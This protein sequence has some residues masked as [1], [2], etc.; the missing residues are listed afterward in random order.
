M[1]GV[2]GG[3]DMIAWDEGQDHA[4][5]EQRAANAGVNVVKQAGIG[6]LVAAAATV[7]ANV[8]P[9]QGGHA[10][11]PPEDPFERVHV[12]HDD[13]LAK[14]RL[15]NEQARQVIEHNIQ[16]RGTGGPHISMDEFNQMQRDL[17]RDFNMRTTEQLAIFRRSP[18]PDEEA[19]SMFNLKETVGQ[20]THAADAADTRA[21]SDTVWIGLR[22]SVTTPHDVNMFVRYTIGGRR[23]TQVAS[24]NNSGVAVPA[25]ACKV[26]VTFSKTTRFAPGG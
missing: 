21:I 7:A 6:S 22:S 15:M 4:P 13:P 19:L 24:N 1:G 9:K 16:N 3:A 23:M 10:V 17:N 26:T 18:K 12:P 25:H 20:D 5:L 2:D 11:K 8:R 14:I